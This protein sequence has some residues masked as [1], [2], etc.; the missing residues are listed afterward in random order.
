VGK[1]AIKLRTCDNIVFDECTIVG[2]YN[3]NITAEM[4]DY[5]PQFWDLA[6][7]SAIVYSNPYN[8]TYITISDCTIRN[9]F[10]FMT[11]GRASNWLIANNTMY[12][13]SE[14]GVNLTNPKGNSSIT[15][16]IITD[17]DPHRCR[18]YWPGTA[19][20]TWAGHEYQT[21]TQD[22]SGATAL[23]YQ[24]G[25][26]WQCYPNRTATPV[27]TTP[28]GVWR[29]DDPNF[30]G[31]YFTP[32]GI[33]S[34]YHADQVVIASNVTGDYTFTITGNWIESGNDATGTIISQSHTFPTT[35]NLTN[36]VILNDG[37][38]VCILTTTGT[39]TLNITH[40]L[41]TKTAGANSALSVGA[42]ATINLYNNIIKGIG[43]YSGTVN[44]DYNCWAGAS[45][46]TDVHQ[47]ETH[48]RYLVNFDTLFVDNDAKDYNLPSGVI[49]INNGDANHTT[50]SD[51]T[52]VVDV[53]ADN[54][55][56]DIGA[57]EY[58]PAVGENNAPVLDVIGNQTVLENRLLTFTVTATDEDLGDTLTFSLASSPSPAGVVFNTTTGIFTWTPTYRQGRT[59]HL[60]F[61]VSDGN[62][63]QSSGTAT[64]T[65]T[66]V[67]RGLIAR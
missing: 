31:V 16:N 34:K 44:G 32:S 50:T 62:G 9:A 49:A 4:S 23:F 57:Y 35:L 60:D 2:R 8:P 63:G 64:I 48:G 10:R 22:G 66:N 11:A 7:D 55:P 54:P 61:V 67:P 59:Y 46:G 19:T 15:G 27:V 40:C 26:T 13:N 43:T 17:T 38:G 28:T 24:L 14:D 18:Y 21:C 30:A 6:E 52:G 33:G 25:T 39:Q 45:N 1:S 36:N 53:R 37:T 51:F 56:P 65:V 29:L 42:S 12:G 3:S 5:Y 47:G 41:L 58:V 20:G